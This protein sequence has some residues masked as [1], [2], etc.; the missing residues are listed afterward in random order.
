VIRG[1]EK[2]YSRKLLERVRKVTPD[3]ILVAMK[4]YMLPVFEP[5]TVTLI[6]T[7]AQSMAMGALKDYGEAG[8]NAKIQTL[9]RL[10]D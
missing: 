10:Q 8:C 5:Q 4:K 7:C 2:D 3:Q 1:T 6:V 9:D